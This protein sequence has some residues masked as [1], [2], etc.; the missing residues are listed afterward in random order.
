MATNDW[1][2]HNLSTKRVSVRGGGQAG[3]KRNVTLT[4]DAVVVADAT[5]RVDGKGWLRSRTAAKG[6]GPKRSVHAWI[7]GD[8]V[9]VDTSPERGRRISYNPHR[10][11]EG[12]VPTF[13]Y[14][15]DGSEWKGS[16]RVL[17]TG[18]YMYEVT[19]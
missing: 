1:T 7:I 8:V 9:E 19:S 14:A 16:A 17:V 18:G 5:P 2:H 12:C 4:A 6:G 13:H 3:G 10:F 11:T 15:D